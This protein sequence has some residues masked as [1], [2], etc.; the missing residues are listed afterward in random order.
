MAVEVKE[1]PDVDQIVVANMPNADDLGGGLVIL[2]DPDCIEA[3]GI[4]GMRTRIMAQHVRE[5]RRALAICS[6]TENTGCS[7]VAANLAASLAQIGVKT[8]VVDADLRNPGL[9]SFFGDGGGP[10]GLGDYLADAN[11]SIDQI[12]RNTSLPDLSIITAGTL[13]PNPQELLSSARFKSL[14]DLLLREF[15]FTI[16][17]TTPTNSCTDAQRVGTVAGY[18][19]VV[20]RKHQSHVKDVSTLVGLLRADRA[21][22]IGTVL[23][24]F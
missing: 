24:N 20:A 2:S 14:V 22:V 7:F 1:M 9:T 21:T 15:D 19:L 8:V 17:D 23:N 12:V 6:P 18:C 10:V 13:H 4:R 16:F 11:V 5:G 3:E